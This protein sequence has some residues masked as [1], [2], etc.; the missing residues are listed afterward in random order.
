MGTIFVAGV[1]AV[2]KTTCCLAA[3]QQLGY[4][5]FSA[6]EIIRTE[7]LSAVPSGT[8]EV[9]DVDENQQLLIRGVDRILDR[10][11]RYFLLDGHFTLLDTLQQVQT[12]DIAVFARLQ[13]DGVVVYRDDPE[14][15]QTRLRE[16]DHHAYDVKLIAMLQDAE[17]THAKTVSSTLQVPIFHLHAFDSAGL[18]ASVSRIWV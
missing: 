12:V 6:S 1:H 5:H 17:L 10:G 13:I 18:I 3:V 14:L 15:I 8:K 16:R 11:Q 4:P 2:G 7:K 9:R